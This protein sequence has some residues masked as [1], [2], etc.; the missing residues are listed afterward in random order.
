KHIKL[1]LLVNDVSLR[2][3]TKDELEKGFGFL[4]SKPPCGFSPVAVTPD[5]LGK[6]WDGEKVNLPIYSH[7]S[8][9]LLGKPN[10]EVDFTFTYPKLIAHGAKTR[11]LGAGTLVGGGTVSNISD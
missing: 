10:A 3:L 7:I 1:I 6:A 8:G 9:K 5:E 4:Q 11:P 2:G